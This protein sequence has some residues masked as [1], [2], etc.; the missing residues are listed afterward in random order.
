MKTTIEVQ[1]AQIQWCAIE[2]RHLLKEKM[3]AYFYHLT[4]G[5]LEE[6]I[7]YLKALI[8]EIWNQE[9]N[10]ALHHPEGGYAPLT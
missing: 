3:F 9:R 1:L 8:K 6:M 4:K 2:M 5:F 7:P 10:W